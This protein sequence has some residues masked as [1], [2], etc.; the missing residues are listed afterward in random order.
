[1]VNINVPVRQTVIRLRE[2]GLW[3]HNPVAPTGECLRMMR[4]LEAEHGPVKHIVLG[5]L[6]LEHKA[7]AGPF[8]KSFPGATVWV[9]PG[10]YSF[11]LPLPLAAFGF[12][13][14]PRLR[15]LPPPGSPDAPPW[16][17]SGEIEYEILGPLR[18]K[19]CPR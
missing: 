2:G 6:S 18:F 3:V 15:V 13:A 16:A 8:S 11:P 10:Q 12:P 14:G 17:S 19:V 5:T 4:D 1:M 7:L 9:Q